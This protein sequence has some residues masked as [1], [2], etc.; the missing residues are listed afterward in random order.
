MVV[1]NLGRELARRGYEVTVFATE[2]S[3]VEGCRMESIGKE[4]GT[5]DVDWR[6][7]ESASFAKARSRL[8]EGCDIIS[9]HTWYAHYYSLYEAK[10]RAAPT[11]IL[12]THHGGL[13]WP[14]YGMQVTRSSFKTPIST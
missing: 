11:I 3:Q 7:T 12:H 6:E 10:I 9:G 4:V 8:A 5:V 13:A 14:P 1:A 2:N